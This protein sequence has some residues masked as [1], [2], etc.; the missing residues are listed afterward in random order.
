MGTWVHGYTEPGRRS[1]VGLYHA[2]V[3][4]EHPHISAVVDVVSSDDGVAVVFHPDACQRVVGDLVVLVHSLGGTARFSVTY[5]RWL[6][7]IKHIVGLGHMHKIK[8]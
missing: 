7:N 3:K 1:R 2:M 8:Y 6:H 5:W 4:R